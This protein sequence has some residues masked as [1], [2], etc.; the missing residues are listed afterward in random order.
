MHL[1]AQ[2]IDDEEGSV[3]RVIRARGIN[4]DNRGVSTGQG[5][6]DAFKGLET[7]TDTAGIYNGPKEY[8]TM[9]EASEKEDEN[10][11]YNKNNVGVSGG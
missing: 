4:D 2:G 3:V 8:T 10:E 6:Y 1:Q 7:T 9:A 5:I 11:D